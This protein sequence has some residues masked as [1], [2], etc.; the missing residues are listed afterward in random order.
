MM[1]MFLNVLF[2]LILFIFPKPFS[3]P[4]Q[5]PPSLLP[6]PLI[7]IYWAVLCQ[8]LLVPNHSSGLS[9]LTNRMQ[10]SKSVLTQG[11]STVEVCMR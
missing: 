9:L 1:E 2:A 6:F 4:Y 3:S 10:T 8:T 11:C 5:L 7:S